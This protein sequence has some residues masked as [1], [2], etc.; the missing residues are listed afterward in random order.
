MSDYK[1]YSA[2]TETLQQFRHRN[3]LIMGWGSIPLLIPFSINSFFQGRYLVGSIIFILIV[4]A[5]L[6][7]YSI[8]KYNRVWAPFW[9]FF[10]LTLVALLIVIPV[11]GVEILFWSYPFLFII[12]FIEER[13][14]ARILSAIAFIALV[15]SAFYYFEH[16]LIIRF[17]STLFML[18]FFSDILV[19]TLTKLQNN[20]TELVNRDPLTNAYN[21]RYME[22][23][24]VD[25]IE[26]CKRGF[27]PASL[28]VI[29]LD[30]FKNI[31][32]SMGHK[33]GDQILI[34]LVELIHQRQRKLD[35]VFRLGGEEFAILLRNTNSEQAC[36]M[37]EDLRQQLE[38]KPFEGR[39]VTASFGV[40]EY[41]LDE[42]EDDWFKRA[43]HYLYEAKKQGRNCVLPKLDS[44]REISN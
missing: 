37:A 9:C 6:N 16:K 27:G 39:P 10:L 13:K 31:N 30:Y 3:L 24:I 18:F 32:D 20:M 2:K 17:S 5:L 19:G 42:S 4:M 36:H 44:D 15:S 38:D 26:E 41:S 35:H 21:R 22:K 8:P 28:I 25:A 29:D 7:A 34:N 1:A 12:S 40:A 11:V 23:C 14:T 43:D 33:A